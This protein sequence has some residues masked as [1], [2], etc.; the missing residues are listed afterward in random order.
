[1]ENRVVLLSPN[2]PGSY[3][4]ANVNDENLALSYLAAVLIEQGYSVEIIDARMNCLS[5]EAVI[6]RI[7]E[8]R[9]FLIGISVISEES[10]SWLESFGNQLNFD[11]PTHVCMGGYYPSLQPDYV[12]DR[13]KFIDTVVIG[14]GEL[15][16]VELAESILKE[17]TYSEI[18]NIAIRLSDGLLHVNKRRPVIAN[19]DSLP[20]PV[21]YAD[22]KNTEIII[23]GSRGCFGKC[24]FCAVG[25]HFNAVR[26]F[27]WRGR[28]P[29][30]IVEEIVRLRK[31]YPDNIRYRF[32][33]PDFFGSS[34]QIHVNRIFK[35]ASLIKKF[36]PGIELYIEARV[37]DLKNKKMLLAL[38]DAGL[39]EIYLGI[40]S[41]SDKILIQMGKNATSN[42]TINAT[43]ML[44]ELDIN[45]QY[46]YMM[47]TPW[48]DY[49]DIIR[50]LALLRIIG[51]VQFDKLF[52]E[53]YVIP[54]TFLVEQIEN[55]CLLVREENTGYFFYE[56]NQLVKNIRLFSIIFETK[57][58]GFSEQ[59]WFLY[60]DVQKHE[61]CHIEGASKI[62]AELS[63]L[64][65]SIFEFCFQKS[66]SNILNENEIE[67]IASEAIYL[68]DDQ[69]LTIRAKL[70]PN[71]FFV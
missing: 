34:S 21:R 31:V 58:K 10:A 30:K 49:D 14:E 61:Q 43:S 56:T 55:Q 69:V 27:S 1:M 67:A 45:Y 47:V 65:I 63:D 18:N 40:E 15:V 54:G 8:I 44:S 52:N 39:K 16:I 60:K 46:G 62:Q 13:F 29:E 33:D 23:E 6:S 37:T 26:K 3:R 28:S 57:Y 48:T 53:L 12:L 42:D 50:N 36:A 22:R 64:F 35:L 51:S 5:A 19:L 41:G 11:F 71:I 24:T 32:I 70:N 9:P 25:P 7:K 66:M 68:F 20:F 59:L 2:T 4:S 38:K 17:Y